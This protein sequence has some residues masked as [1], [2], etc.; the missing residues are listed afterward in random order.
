MTVKVLVAVEE[1]ALV[2]TTGF[3]LPS[4]VKPYGNVTATCP[5]AIAVVA[6]KEIVTVTEVAP[7]LFSLNSIGLLTQ[8]V[9]G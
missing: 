7:A 4:K 9:I 1:T 3:T 5:D 8:L 6:E 2:N